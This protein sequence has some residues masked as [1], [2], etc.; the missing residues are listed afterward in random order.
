MAASS[1]SSHICHNGRLR[2]GAAEDGTIG[3]WQSRTNGFEGKIRLSDSAAAKLARC[4]DIGRESP[5]KAP[6]HQ[7]REQSDN[8]VSFDKKAHRLR[9]TKDMDQPPGKRA[10][11]P[12]GRSLLRLGASE[13]SK[14]CVRFC[15]LTVDAV[16]SFGS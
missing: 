13:A 7:Q 2:A 8:P 14:K 12:H 15:T 5:T 10:S 1:Q 3:A 11:R 9:Q 16:S 6:R 4:S